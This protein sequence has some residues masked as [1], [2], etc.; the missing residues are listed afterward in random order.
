MSSEFESG[1]FVRDGAWHGEG[2]VLEAAPETPEAG[3][4]AGN[5]AWNVIQRPM[6][7]QKEDGSFVPVESHVCNVR[8]SDGS[9]FGPV[10]VSVKPLQNIDA[11]KLFQPLIDAK[12]IEM[13]AV[14]SLRGGRRVCFLAELTGSRVEVV[15]GDELRRYLLLAHAHDSSLAIRWGFTDI[16][17]VC[18]NTLAVAL[19][20]G[21]LLKHKHTANALINLEAAR[22]VFDARIGQMRVQADLF[23]AMARK[24]LAPNEALNYI[25]ETFHEGAGMPG[26][27]KTVVRCAERCLELFENG[28]GAQYGRGT[29]WNAF[30][31]VTEYVT[32]ERGKTAD[33][34]A[35]SNWFGPG[36]QVLSRAVTV[37]QAIL[38]HSQ[39][40]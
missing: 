21:D 10:G 8:D 32:H 25:R 13:N 30:N 20:Q 31:A 38:S 6:F 15:P 14:I 7:Y 23:Q 33:S 19:E 24:Q 3:L 4:Q 34:R 11:Y 17:V 29:L 5:M 28:R 37:A 39:A 27:E 26:N 18:A 1:F 35:D 9:S 22:E 16:R 12:L 40:T 36:A 2:N